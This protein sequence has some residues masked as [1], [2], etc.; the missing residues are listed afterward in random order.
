MQSVSGLVAPRAGRR[1]DARIRSGTL[2]T[3]QS[4]A[5]SFRSA[6]GQYPEHFRFSSEAAAITVTVPLSVAPAGGLVSAT[7]GAA[8]SFDTLKVT[9]LELSLPAASCASA[10]ST[11]LPLGTVDVIHACL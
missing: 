11:W 6:T 4:F 2:R 5:G 9:V 1:H 3:R 8:V 10:V 7:V